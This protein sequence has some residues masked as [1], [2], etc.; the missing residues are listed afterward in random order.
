MT[1]E[2]TKIFVLLTVGSHVGVEWSWLQ[3]VVTALI[4]AIEMGKTLIFQNNH[5]AAESNTREIIDCEE[6][7]LFKFKYLYFYFLL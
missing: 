7:N 4:L 3:T 1:T 2:E 5:L 6:N